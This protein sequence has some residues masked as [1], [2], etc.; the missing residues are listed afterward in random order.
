MN[1]RSNLGEWIA[2]RFHS[3]TAKGYGSS[4]LM[5]TLPTELLLKVVFYVSSDVSDL[6]S[7]A[8]VNRY[9]RFLARDSLVWNSVLLAIGFPFHSRTISSVSKPSSSSS[10]QTGLAVPITGSAASRMAYYREVKK[11]HLHQQGFHP[12]V[13]HLNLPDGSHMYISRPL[14]R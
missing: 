6:L 2:S 12:L 10:S 1:F 4:V 11:K 7:L 9:W 5:E 13:E 8:L 3:L 14:M